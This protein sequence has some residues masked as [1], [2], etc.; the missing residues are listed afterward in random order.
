MPKHNFRKKKAAAASA[1]RVPER[2][3]CI[4]ACELLG[5]SESL[6]SSEPK[7]GSKL[8]RF[9]VHKALITVKIIRA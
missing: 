9:F 5:Q 4:D 6:L 7:L 8:L 1:K 2:A 3:I